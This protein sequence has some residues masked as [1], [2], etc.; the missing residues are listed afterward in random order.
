MTLK[1]WQEKYGV[2]RIDFAKVKPSGYDYE[3]GYDNLICPYCK[4]TIEYE[5]E[6]IDSLFKGE[7]YQ[8]PNCEKWFY[9]EAEMNITTTCTPMEETVLR[10]RRYIQDTYDYIDKC[11]RLGTKWDDN[12]YG[13]VEWNVYAEYARPY[14]ENQENN[15]DG[16]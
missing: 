12:R 6:E 13:N 16:Q 3:S 9:A 1:Q 14:F 7:A 15:H 2:K 5:S 8:C 4:V 10:N 11:E